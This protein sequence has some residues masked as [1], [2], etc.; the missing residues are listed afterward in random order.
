MALVRL[1]PALIVDEFVVREY[2]H[3]DDAQVSATGANTTTNPLGIFSGE[4]LIGGT[5]LHDRNEPGDVELS[6]WL[7]DEW[8]GKG[9]ATKVAAALTDYA[10]TSPNVD[11]VLIKHVPDNERSARI[12]ARLGF[13]RIANMGSCGSCGDVEHV[14]WAL[15][16]AEWETR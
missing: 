1:H 6:Y 3:A 16:R 9:I 8:Q 5:G 2:D 4:T 12:P 10:F 13:V 7:L 14:T 11:R 15:T